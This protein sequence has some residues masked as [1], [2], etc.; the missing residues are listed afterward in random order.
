MSRLKRISSR[1]PSAPEAARGPDR[2]LPAARALQGRAPAIGAALCCAA[3]PAIALWAAGCRDD[4]CSD[5]LRIAVTVSI[6]AADSERPDRVTVERLSEEDCGLVS[7]RNNA[8][9][10]QCWEQDGGGEYVVR[11]YRGKDVWTDTENVPG[12]ACHVTQRA[13][14]SFDLDV[15]P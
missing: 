9:V 15:P 4:G 14:I 12:D 6:D 5:E 2:E 3:V 13:E 7:S 10:Y 8:K 11:V 1:T